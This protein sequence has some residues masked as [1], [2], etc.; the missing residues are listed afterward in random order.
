MHSACGG[1]KTAAFES[2][3]SNIG[4]DGLVASHDA[5]DL[6]KDHYPYLMTEEGHVSQ[7]IPGESLNLFRGETL[8]SNYGYSDI[9][10][11]TTTSGWWFWKKTYR[12]VKNDNILHLATIVSNH[13]DFN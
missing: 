1:N 2:C 8:V 7:V 9:E 6:Y 11:E 12:N 13:F 3:V 10:T 4:P 5:P